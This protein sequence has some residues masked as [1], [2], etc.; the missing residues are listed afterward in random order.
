ML[1]LLNQLVF[2][3]PVMDKPNILEGKGVYEVDEVIGVDGVSGGGHAGE[4]LQ[5]SQNNTSLNCPHDY[6]CSMTDL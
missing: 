4:D 2:P 5:S 3:L 6:C 1:P